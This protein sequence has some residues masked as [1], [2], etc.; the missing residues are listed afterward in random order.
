MLLYQSTYQINF[1]KS[2]SVN[3]IKIASYFQM[4]SFSTFKSSR[5]EVFFTEGFFKTYSQT[6]QGVGVSFLMIY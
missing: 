1:I 4:L 3:I 2:S 6:S 5:P